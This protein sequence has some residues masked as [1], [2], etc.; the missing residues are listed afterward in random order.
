MVEKGFFYCNG[1]NW[2]T[3]KLHNFPAYYIKTYPS[4]IF[5]KYKK[6]EKVHRNFY[7]MQK[8]YDDF[9]APFMSYLGITPT[10][11]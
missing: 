5:L 11:V 3:Y 7:E 6:T 9:T 8:G 10:K 2:K 1:N 4:T